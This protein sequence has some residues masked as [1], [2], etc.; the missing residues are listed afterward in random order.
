MRQIT[1]ESTYRSEDAD[2]RINTRDGVFGCYVEMLEAMLEQLLSMCDRYSKC[3][4]MVFDLHMKCHTETNKPVSDFYRRLIKKLKRTYQLKRVGYSWARELNL[5][6][7]RTDKQHY[8][9]CLILDG[10]R[11]QHPSKVLQLVEELWIEGGHPKPFVSKNCFYSFGRD[12][13]ET[14]QKAFFRISYQAKVRDK[15][16]KAPATNNYSTSRLNRLPKLLEGSFRR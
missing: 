15:G 6:A 13:I 2:W 3:L 7:K 11:V 8:H 9:C 5:V 10:N 16:N 14:A 4:V 12:D 1:Y